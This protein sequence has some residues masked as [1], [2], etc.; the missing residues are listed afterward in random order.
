MLPALSR[1]AS[2]IAAGSFTLTFVIEPPI[3]IPVV[4]SSTTEFA[5]NDEATPMPMFG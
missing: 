3:T 1:P 5:T 4:G 2:T